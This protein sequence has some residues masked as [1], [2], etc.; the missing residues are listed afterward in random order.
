MLTANRTRDCCRYGQWRQVEGCPPPGRGASHDPRVWR[1]SN[2]SRSA[3]A[4]PPTPVKKTANRR[5][6]ACRGGGDWGI[7]VGRQHA[8]VQCDPTLFDELEP[9]VAEV[10]AQTD[11]RLVANIEILW[12]KSGE[13]AC[14]QVYD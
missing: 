1:G 10:G 3:P 11:L 6:A 9:R 12:V 14:S 2:F 13:D 5:R 8:D 4:P 7:A